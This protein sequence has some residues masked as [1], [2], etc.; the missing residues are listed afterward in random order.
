VSVGRARK[1]DGVRIKSEGVISKVHRGVVVENKQMASIVSVLLQLF[2]AKK[3]QRW[4]SELL[5]MS[6][7]TIRIS[8]AITS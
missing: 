5:P 6:R 2:F 1:G 7:C 8:K 4:M 3:T